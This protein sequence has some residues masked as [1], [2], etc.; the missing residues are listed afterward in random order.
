[1]KRIARVTIVAIV[2][3]AVVA[4]AVPLPLPLSRALPIAVLVAVVAAPILVA[5]VATPVVMTVVVPV[6]AIVPAVVARHA[7]EKKAKG[8]RPSRS[9]LSPAPLSCVAYDTTSYRTQLMMG[10]LVRG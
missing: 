9:E 3:V 2:T 6:A 5:V 4:I 10:R 7:N 8:T 1:M